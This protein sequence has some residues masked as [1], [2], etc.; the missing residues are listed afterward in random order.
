MKN[1]HFAAGV[2]SKT[3]GVMLCL[4]GDGEASSKEDQS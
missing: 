3:C 1:F 4:L 2:D